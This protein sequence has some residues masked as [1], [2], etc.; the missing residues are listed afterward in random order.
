MFS[1]I[2]MER[3]LFAK[4]CRLEASI[5]SFMRERRGRIGEHPSQMGLLSQSDQKETYSIVC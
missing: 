1:K 2:Q 5:S 4:I 3:D